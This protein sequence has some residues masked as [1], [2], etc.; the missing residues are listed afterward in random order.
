MQMIELVTIQQLIPRMGKLGVTTMEE[1]EEFCRLK[2]AM[3][4]LY[5]FPKG[6][7]SYGDALRCGDFIQKDSIYGHCLTPKGEAFLMAN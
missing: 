1:A 7:M 6:G 4:N 3:R 2:Q 5:A